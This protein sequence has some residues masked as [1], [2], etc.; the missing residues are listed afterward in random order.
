MS[1]SDEPSSR[2]YESLEAE[3]AR[4]RARIRDL[5]SKRSHGDDYGRRRRNRTSAED[6]VRDLPSHASDAADRLTRGLTYAFAEHLQSGVDALTAV[7]DE[8]FGG[9][10]SGRTTSDR[11]YTDEP[12]ENHAKSDHENEDDADDRRSGDRISD[13]MS[14]LAHGVVEGIHQSLDAPRRSA[15][16]FFDEIYDEQDRP[17]SY[18]KSYRRETQEGGSRVR[19]ETTERKPFVSPE[20]RTTSQKP[21]NPQS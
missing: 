14:D 7:A 5:E 2:S 1:S 6:R 3:N 19:K 12:G 16:R 18:S 17:R 20:T 13:A 8:V 10:R 11:S 9:P 21:T 4:L 15:E